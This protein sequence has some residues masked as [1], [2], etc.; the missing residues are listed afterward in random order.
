MNPPKFSFIIVTYNNP[1]TIGPCL[2]SVAALTADPFEIIVV[3][4][5][6]DKRT[7]LAVNQFRA[8]QVS[9][10]IRVIEPGENIGFSRACNA[11]ARVANGKFLFFLNPDTQLINDAAQSLAHC[12]EMHPSAWAAGPVLF[13]S[14]GTIARS[15]RNLPNLGR[16][17]LD[18]TGIDQWLGAYKLLRFAHDSPRKVEQIIGAAM[19]FRRADYESLGG[20]DERFFVYFEEVDFCKRIK[21]AG[22]EI[23]FWPEARVR[24]LAGR[25]CEASSVRARMIFTLRQSRRKY[26]EK[27]FGTFGAAALE[28]VNRLEGLQKF[29]VLA[30]LSL[31]QRNQSYR[32]KAQGFWAV[33]TGI[34]PRI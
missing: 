23:W 19:L 5:S 18:A 21:E 2:Y 9:V 11:G 33:A 13:Q 16:I 28:I 3:D 15:C 22:H 20:M 12:L 25:S 31:L 10:N 17:V 30:L 4:N 34:A 26:F 6:P 32:E 8:S 14:D 1:D 29:P 27:H 7:V 24:H